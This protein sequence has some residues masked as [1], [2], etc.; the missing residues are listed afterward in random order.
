MINLIHNNESKSTPYVDK[1]NIDKKVLTP[2]VCT[3]PSRLNKYTHDSI[4]IIK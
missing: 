1:K 3:N 2:L 4:Y